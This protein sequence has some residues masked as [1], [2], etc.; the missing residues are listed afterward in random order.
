MISKKMKRKV[1][2]HNRICDIDI[3][4]KFKIEENEKGIKKLP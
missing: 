4:T 1:V 3:K 2:M